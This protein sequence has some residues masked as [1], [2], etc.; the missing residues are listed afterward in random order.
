[1]YII[2]N[3][4]IHI[5]Y[6]NSNTRT[7]PKMVD[8]DRLFVRKSFFDSVVAINHPPRSAHSQPMFP[9]NAV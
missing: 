5:N 7:L 4:N 8:R 1:M 9:I 6:R 2:Y 3:I